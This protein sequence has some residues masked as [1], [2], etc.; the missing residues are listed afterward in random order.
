MAPQATS[1]TAR[2]SARAWRFTLA[3]AI[4]VA[5]GA[6][7][8]TADPVDVGD[9]PVVTRPET[10]LAPDDELEDV[11][12]ADDDDTYDGTLTDDGGDLA[13]T[14]TPAP[15]PAPEPIPPTRPGCGGGAQDQDFDGICDDEDIDSYP[16]SNDDD[17]DGIPD[18]EDIDQDDPYDWND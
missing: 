9:D 1:P 18:Y 12:D 4:A 8:N 16:G 5:L 13:P 7:A 2:A 15:T 6:C 14:P 17:Y 10:T 11:D 3:A